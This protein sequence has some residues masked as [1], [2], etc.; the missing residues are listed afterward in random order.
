M[1]A[2]FCGLDDRKGARILME[3][4]EFKRRLA[5]AGL[6]PTDAVVQQ[7][8]AALPLIEAMRARV[9]RNYDMA[10][11]PAATFNARLGQ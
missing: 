4:E 6:K 11:E 8:Y 1:A 2:G 7:M 9:N 3:I 5:E 10:D